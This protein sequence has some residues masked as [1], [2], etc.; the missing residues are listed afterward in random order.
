MENLLSKR[1][2]EFPRKLKF[3]CFITVMN[4]TIGVGV[5]LY[6]VFQTTQ[7]TTNGTEEHFRGS[8]IK[9]D[10]EIP[11]KYPKP[12]SELLNTTHTHILSMTFIFLIIGG[13]FYFNS[14]ITGILKTFLII[15]PFI[16]IL[17]TFGGI[18][19]IRFIHPSFSYLVIISGSLMYLCFFIMIITISYELIMKNNKRKEL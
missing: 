5:G 12:T 9:D 19:L 15:E 2:Y 18:W 14:I 11:E 6:Y 1:L 3:L 16:S 8:I 17:L 4:L 10:F 13:L 7:L